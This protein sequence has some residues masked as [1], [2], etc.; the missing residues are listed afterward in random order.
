MELSAVQYNGRIFAPVGSETTDE[1]LTGRY[2]QDGDLVW[3]EFSG[4]HVRTGRLVGRC[5]ADGT[6]DAAYCQVLADGGVVAG[7]CVSTP[8]VLPD[9]RLRLTERWRRF[10]GT[11]GLSQIEEI[12]R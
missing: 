6:I 1:M 5:D 12:A 3:A 10:D 8:S 2:S 9:G 11:T 4:A 7:R